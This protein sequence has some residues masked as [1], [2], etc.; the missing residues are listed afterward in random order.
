MKSGAKV[1][2]CGIK[3]GTKED[4]RVTITYGKPLDFSKYKN[5]KDKEIL[6]EITDKIMKNIIELTK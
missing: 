6:D 4:K 5:T 3:G 1:I 2:P